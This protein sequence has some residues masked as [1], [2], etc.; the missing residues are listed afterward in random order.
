MAV[1]CD[2]VRGFRGFDLDLREDR[3]RGGKLESRD[4]DPNRR[5]PAARLGDRFFNGRG[6]G[7]RADQP[8]KLALS[9]PLGAVY[10]GVVAVLLPRR[11]G[12]RGLEGRSR[13]Q[14]ERGLNADPG[15][16]FPA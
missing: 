1:I 8:E 3:D 5:R 14:N 6:A 2:T 13:R 11:S 16:S 7:D 12:R 9:D 10:G 15:V 4:G